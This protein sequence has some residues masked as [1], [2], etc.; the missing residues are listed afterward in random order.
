MAGEVDPVHG[1]TAG[2][3]SRLR[4]TVARLP[5]PAGRIDLVTVTLGSHGVDLRWICGAA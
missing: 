1:F 2:K 4:A 5:E 3:E